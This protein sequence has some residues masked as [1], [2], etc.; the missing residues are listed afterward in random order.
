M[1]LRYDYIDLSNYLNKFCIPE[2]IKKHYFFKFETH[3][4]IELDI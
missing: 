2:I 3:T 1:I 4:Q